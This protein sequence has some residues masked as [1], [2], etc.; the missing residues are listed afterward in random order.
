MELDGLANC[1]VGQTARMLPRDS[2]NGAQLAGGEDAI[3]DGNTHHEVVGDQA[4]TALAAD[5]THA[6]ALRVNAPPLE[7][8][9]GP[10]GNHTRPAGAREGANL[11]KGRPGILLLLQPLGSLGA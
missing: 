5:G 6:V 11:V 7:V 2:T 3:G 8:E 4:F 10:F 9:G 1:N